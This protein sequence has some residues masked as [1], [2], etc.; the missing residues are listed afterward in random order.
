MMRQQIT[1]STVSIPSTLSAD[2]RFVFYFISIVKCCVWRFLLKSSRWS[3]LCFEASL[4]S[5]NFRWETAIFGF[6]NRST[7]FRIVYFYFIKQNNVTSKLSLL[8]NSGECIKYRNKKDI[9]LVLM[10][11]ILKAKKNS[12]LSHRFKVDWQK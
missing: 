3:L 8:Q 5:F 6:S 11:A 4:V 10:V 9:F 1:L 7:E 12:L 2:S